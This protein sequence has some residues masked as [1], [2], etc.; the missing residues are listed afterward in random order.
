MKIRIALGLTLCSVCACLGQEPAPQP[1]KI[2]KVEFLKSSELK[3]GMKGYTWTVFQ[4]SDPEPIPVEII[5]IMKNSLGPGQD[6]ILAKLGGKVLQTNVAGGMS[7]SPVYI[8]GKLA[9][10]VSRRVSVFSPE[11]VCGITPIEQMLEVSALDASRP[12]DALASSAIPVPSELLARAFAGGG[13]RDLPR[14]PVMLTPIETPLVL[15]G[16]NEGVLRDIAP[17]FGELGL[18][19]VQGGGGGSTSD[20]KPVAGWA[21]SLRPGQMVGG[22][23]V[24]GDMTVAVQGTVTYNDGHRVLAFGHSLLNLGPVDIPMSRSE[25]VMTMASSY[26][27]NKFANTTDVVG[28]VRQDRSGGVLGI[29]GDQAH[30]IPMHVTVRSFAENGAIRAEKTFKYSVFV[31]ERYTPNLVMTTLYNTLSGVNEFSEQNTYRLSGKIELDGGRSLSLATMQASTGGATPAPMLLAGW[32]GDRVN[33]LFLNTVTPPRFKRADVSVDL[34]PER[35]IA[36]IENAW[37]AV[38]EAQAGQV[39]PVKV[40]VRPYR[41]ERIE[42][43]IEVR[44]P[45]G[46]PA[47]QHRILLSDADTLNRMQS[48]A[49]RVN[50]FIDLD[51][52]ISLIN[53]ERANT[54]LYVSLLQTASTVYYDDKTLPSL[55]SSVLNV[56]QSGPLASR[57][58]VASRETVLEQESIPLDTV[59]SGSYSLTIT[60]K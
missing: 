47:G 51:Q 39:V 1:P 16:F 58:F 43:D 18:T 30:T 55:P 14:S 50:R 38:N 10:A 52:T 53:Q 8:D 6:L 48:A 60:V 54:R 13:P 35:R 22:L 19:V 2:G 57:P 34:L 42:K 27:P 45:A 7:G 41:G 23:L 31:Q 21:A 49:G 12:A 29:L 40:F 37:A 25:V 28:A 32:V 46:F 11:S 33:R 9:G 36:T 15:S 26:Q 17:L 3:P 56:M 44:I 59:V 4:G 5:G 20:A 24:T